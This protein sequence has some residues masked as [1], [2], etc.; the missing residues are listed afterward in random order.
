M[1]K[2]V[3]L[4]LMMLFS[5]AASAGEPRRSAK[6]DSAHSVA[7]DAVIDD[8]VFT[9][10]SGR[11]SHEREARAQLQY[12]IGALNQ[13]ASGPQLSHSQV[14]ITSRERFVDE[15]S[16]RR[17][18]RVHYSAT[19]LVAWAVMDR[20]RPTP[21]LI[22]LILPQRADGTG[23]AQFYDAYNIR[24]SDQ[25]GFT[26]DRLTQTRANYWYHFRP[27]IQECPLSWQWSETAQ[28]LAQ[29][30]TLRLSPHA[31]RTE[32]RYPE[33]D[34]FWRDGLLVATLMYSKYRAGATGTDDAGVRSFI[35]SY[36]RLMR[37]LGPDVSVEPAGLRPSAANP[38]LRIRGVAS[39]G[40]RVDITMDLLDELS[41]ADSATVSRLATRMASSDVVA[42]NGHAGL[43]ANVRALVRM[44]RFEPG[45]H[46][47]Y[48]INGCD[49][50]SYA[51]SRLHGSVR[52]ANPG[53]EPT[54]YLD[55]ILNAMPG[56][57]ST[58]DDDLD[59]L[60][61]ALL[62]RDQSYREML[63]GFSPLRRAL[64]MGEEDNPTSP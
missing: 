45:R 14:S 36:D 16:G 23:L 32:D 22:E 53:E 50:F 24:C 7:L 51:D 61:T 37:R 15:S 54:R 31:G 19:F 6:F 21:D 40:G 47:L 39:G 49:T 20:R 30:I 41:S 4:L 57:F 27:L 60:F 34:E 2:S 5:T 17:L 44:A 38:S 11:G 25:Y 13:Y 52:D 62:G 56:F 43:G 55:V 48:L 42:Y 28:R 8:G 18:W 46:Q 63:S 3:S 29:R 12:S 59:A 26:G 1:R 35:A 64:V 33:Y 9:T 10:A 58:M